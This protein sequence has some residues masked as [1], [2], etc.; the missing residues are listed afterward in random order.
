MERNTF[1]KQ[2]VAEYLKSVY[3]HPSAETVFKEVKKKIPNISQATVYRILKQMVKKGEAQDIE[4]EVCRYDGNACS[5]AHFICRKCNSIYDIMD[6]CQGCDVL[7]TKNTK[8]GKIN[9][10]KINFY[11][12]CNKCKK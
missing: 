9:N 11:G 7:K 10:F 4:T 6:F 2:V 3:C 12:I 5:H 1:Q 8:V